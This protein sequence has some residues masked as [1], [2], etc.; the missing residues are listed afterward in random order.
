MN[1]PPLNFVFGSKSGVGISPLEQHLPPVSPTENDDSIG[2]DAVMAPIVERE[3]T[4]LGED[5]YDW[6]E[7][8]REALIVEVIATE[9]KT[10]DKAVMFDRE[11]LAEED[12]RSDKELTKEDLQMMANLKKEMILD[13][14]LDE[15]GIFGDDLIVTEL[16]AG[17][18]NETAEHELDGNALVVEA[19]LGTDGVSLEHMVS[20]Q[21]ALIVLP[22]V[23]II[24]EQEGSIA[25]D[26]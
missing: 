26:G 16:Q 24:H 13:G 6:G 22:L 18:E 25:D 9:Q 4:I 11:K 14:L 2:D 15:G 17:I 23:T 3:A 1:L 20:E 10:Y 8:T 5:E 21:M 12:H 7:K 19:E